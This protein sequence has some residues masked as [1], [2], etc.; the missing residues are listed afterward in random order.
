MTPDKRRSAGFSLWANRGRLDGL[1]VVECVHR[2]A[3]LPRAIPRRFDQDAEGVCRT[4]GFNALER[5]KSGDFSARGD[6]SVVPLDPLG[7]DPAHNRESDAD[8]GGLSV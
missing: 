7:L 1:M 8:R 5:L 3:S 6:P 2:S 4:V